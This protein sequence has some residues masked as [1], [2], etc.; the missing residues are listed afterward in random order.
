[1]IYLITFIS[2]VS[3]ALGQLLLKLG[4]HERQEI[5]DFF[6]L[7]NMTG[8]TC[9]VIGLLLWVYSLSRLPMSVVYAFSTVTFI[10][11]YIL[12]HFLLNE[13]LPPWSMVGIALIV[14]GF[15]CIIL[16]QM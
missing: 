8:L 6:N 16:G 1:M 9:Y 12:S 3:A 15:L 14:V 10:L 4:S 7:Y 11:V 13:S 5:L 2:A